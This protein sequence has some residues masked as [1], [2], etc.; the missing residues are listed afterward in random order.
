V[1][2]G[3]ENESLL[4]AMNTAIEE[5]RADGTLSEISVKYFGSDIS[6]NG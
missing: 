1:R 6:Q 2:K 5:L 4:A 3:A